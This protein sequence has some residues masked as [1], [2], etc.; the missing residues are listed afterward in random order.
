MEIYFAN[1]TSINCL[2]SYQIDVG[3]NNVE[4]ILTILKVEKTLEVNCQRAML[5]EILFYSLNYLI[6]FYSK[7]ANQ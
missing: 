2:V 4:L 6:T 7:R 3:I 1:P 5:L